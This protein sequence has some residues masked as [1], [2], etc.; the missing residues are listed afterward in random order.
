MRVL[1]LHDCS[2]TCRDSTNMLGII[3]FCLLF[4]VTLGKMG[5]KAS[6]VVDLFAIIDDAVMK[7]VG[8]IMWIS[9]IGITSVITAKILQVDDLGTVMTQLT[10][11][12][13]T[14]CGGI[15]LYQFTILQAIYFFFVRK[16]P[17]RF[18]ATMFQ[19]WMTA[20][21]TAST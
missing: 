12:I 20:F 7:M 11:F 17:F 6:G 1:S 5:Q 8:A 14:V 16:N 18:W 3:F 4:G 2:V 10:M 15:F 21:A 19:A 13:I 9:P